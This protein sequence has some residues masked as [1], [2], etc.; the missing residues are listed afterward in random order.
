VGGGEG[1]RQVQSEF[2]HKGHDEKGGREGGRE[3]GKTRRATY[4]D[5]FGLLGAH[6]IHELVVHDFDEFLVRR[7]ALRHVHA[8]AREG[9]KEGGREGRKEGGVWAR[10]MPA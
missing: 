8:W 9:E 3:G 7:H 1:G 2:A 4:L 6:E 5:Q 10:P